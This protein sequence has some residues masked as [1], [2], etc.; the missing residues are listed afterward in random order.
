MEEV[1]Y[2]SKVNILIICR[3]SDVSD[4]M[5]HI[6]ASHSTFN[7]QSVATAFGDDVTYMLVGCDVQA[8]HRS[9]I[10]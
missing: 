1:P 4:V 5:D 10:I 2:I 6:S 8:V 7:R 9:I 3:S